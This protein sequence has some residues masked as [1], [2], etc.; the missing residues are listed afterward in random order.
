MASS[1]TFGLLK[2]TPAN[3]NESR[4]FFVIPHFKKSIYL[5][6]WLFDIT[7][8]SLTVGNHKDRKYI[9]FLLFFIA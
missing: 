6:V 5:F 4:G 2:S 8:P 1:T 9:G 3:F 7:F